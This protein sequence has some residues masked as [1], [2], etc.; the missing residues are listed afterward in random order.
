M[1]RGAVQD[2]TGWEKEI[3]AATRHQLH[4]RWAASS[5]GKASSKRT[6]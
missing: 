1:D 3:V 2:Q 6:P 4:D 5:G